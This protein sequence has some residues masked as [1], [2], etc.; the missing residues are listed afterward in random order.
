MT[1]KDEPPE[2]IGAQHATGEEKRHSSSFRM[3]EK[4]EPKKK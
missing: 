2:L 1:L 3:N 4:A